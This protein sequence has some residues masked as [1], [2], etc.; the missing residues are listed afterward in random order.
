MS[1]VF[2]PTGSLDVTADPGL[3]PEISSGASSVQSGAMVRCK[4]LVLDRIGKA[5]TRRGVKYL[6]QSA[7]STVDFYGFFVL[8]GR[9]INLYDT[10]YSTDHLNIGN[11]GLAAAFNGGTIGNPLNAYYSVVF[12][13]N[14]TKNIFFA[15]KT[16]AFDGYVG[17]SYYIPY[18]WGLDAPTDTPIAKAGILTGLTGDYSAKY[19]IGRYNGSVLECESNPSAASATVTLADGSLQ[20]CVDLFAGE[21]FLQGW[22]EYTI[23]LRFYRTLHEGAIYYLETTVEISA[24]LASASY[25]SNGVTYTYTWEP[26]EI[27]G[28]AYKFT[29]TDATNNIEYTHEWELDYSVTTAVNYARFTSPGDF[30]LVE[31]NVADTALGS[32]LAYDHDVPPL[33]NG[34]YGPLFNGTLFALLDNLLYYSKPGQPEYWP[35]AYYLEISTPDDP[36]TTMVFHNGQPYVFT[37]RK[38]AYIQGTGNDSFFPIVVDAITGAMGRFCAK[39]VHGVGIFHVGYDGL[40][41]YSGDDRNISN[42][43]FRAIFSPYLPYGLHPYNYQYGYNH[44]WEADSYYLHYNDGTF[45]FTL[46]DSTRSTENTYAWE[47]YAETETRTDTVTYRP[48]G[49]VDFVY[50]D[51]RAT[52]NGLVVSG[53]LANAWLAIYENKL[54]FGFPRIDTVYP[55]QCLVMDLET[56][57]VS[58]YTWPTVGEIIQVAVDDT[59]NRLLAA[60]DEGGMWQLE[61]QGETLDRGSVPDLV[62]AL[63]LDTDDTVIAW[64]IQ[65]KEFYLP[66]RRHFPR[67]AKYDI[68]ATDTTACTGTYVLDGATLQQHTITGNRSTNRRLIA[69]GNGKRASLKIEGSGPVEIFTV[70][71]E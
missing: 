53:D 68:N 25:P 58:S 15:D 27:T 6:W 37:R 16:E 31:L 50:A 9:I 20:V 35:A 40:Y 3:L 23:K 48:T 5:I 54:Y 28:E 61:A 1:I 39:S 21:E 46:V 51:S 14:G 43:A 60:D 34:Y 49:P 4:N 66:T 7:W 57:Q 32:E 10:T 52:V 18:Q 62:P 47:A 24:Y 65:S 29:T 56:K 11:V 42:A 33:S 22:D 38:M 55:T 12:A 2:K 63:S 59:K 26:A 69:T 70:E 71:A 64:E 19:T 41:L 13:G 45:H 44:P 30:V 17:T 67:W 8:A 36:C